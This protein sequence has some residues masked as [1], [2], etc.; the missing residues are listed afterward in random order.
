VQGNRL[1]WL[2]ILELPLLSYSFDIVKN[3]GLAQVIVRDAFVKFYLDN[4]KYLKPKSWLYREV[5]NSSLARLRDSKN[6]SVSSEQLD[7]FNDTPGTTDSCP[8]NPLKKDEKIRRVCHFQRQLPEDLM[9]LLTLKFGKKLNYKEIAKQ[10]ETSVS[11]VGYDLQKLINELT[12]ELQEEGI[13]E[14]P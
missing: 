2:E 11:R 12:L 9:E 5:R 14:C 1:H 10:K 8:R 6:S 13:V 4:E 3:E 7:L